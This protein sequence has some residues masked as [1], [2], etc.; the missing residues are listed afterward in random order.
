M[1]T[2]RIFFDSFVN[3]GMYEHK[4]PRA[5]WSVEDVLQ[6]MNQCG[7]DAAVCSYNLSKRYDPMY[8]NLQLMEII[9]N[10]ERLYPCWVVMPHHSGDFAKHGEVVSQL[11]YYDVRAVK[12]WPKT[13]NY[14]W[15]PWCMGSLMEA[16]SKNEYPVMVEID[17]F[18]RNFDNVF[19]FLSVYNHVPILLQGCDWSESRYLY[20]LMEK[21]K[22]LYIEFSMNQANAAIEIMYQRYGADRLLFG[23]RAPLQSMGAARSFIDYSMI[24]EDAKRK[25]S[26]QNL[27]RLTGINPVP[28]KNVK[29]DDPIIEKAKK[30]LPLDDILV[31]DAHAHCGH[32][33]GEGV[34]T[35]PMP[36]SDV[37]F[38]L[39]KNNLMGVEKVCL[40]SWVG[41]FTPY[42]REGNDITGDA[43]MRY[44]ERIV[45]Y[46]TIDPTH[47]NDIKSEINR[48]YMKL[49]LKGLKPYHLC[50]LPYD[51]PLYNPWW[52]FA[53]EH[54]LFAL[55]HGAQQEAE[56]LSERYKNVSFILAHRAATYP[57]IRSAAELIK[58]R[59]N[60]YAE[61]TYTDVPLN[62]IEFLVELVGADRV[63]YGTDSPMRDP[64]PQFG[65]L[66]YTKLSY[67]EKKKIFGENMSKILARC[68]L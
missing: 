61:I 23:S 28:V 8:G 33:G 67:E 46:A 64:R 32:K 20:P 15:Q 66:A 41:I 18:S 49:G 12:I 35:I 50:G 42:D 36:Q 29:K 5:P 38:M 54:H 57:V 39:E 45:G 21:F 63:L 55:I 25:I 47:N 43:V 16:L 17:E 27:T 9:K 6:E 1:D 68:R 31:I 19:N 44:P 7:I 30:G 37:E 53:D 62:A 65:W 24:P 52:E 40:S 2:E 51:H 59:E 26:G 13:Q 3:F 34:G 56:I 22:N 4:D 58:K 11:K 48:A 10:K 14:S 60:V